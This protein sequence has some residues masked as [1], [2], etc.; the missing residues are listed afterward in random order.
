LI[1]GKKIFPRFRKIQKDKKSVAS[2]PTRCGKGCQEAQLEPK[3]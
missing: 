2:I 3:I 1:E